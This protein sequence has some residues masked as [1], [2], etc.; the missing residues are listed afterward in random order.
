MTSS[1]RAIIF[2]HC[3]SYFTYVK[4]PGGKEC[5]INSRSY[6]SMVKCQVCGF[7]YAEA[8]GI[9]FREKQRKYIRLKYNKI[10]D[11]VVLITN[12]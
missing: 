3:D 1:A 12:L 5:G 4:L 9:A 6:H 2:I 11:F 7:K 10:I 8:L